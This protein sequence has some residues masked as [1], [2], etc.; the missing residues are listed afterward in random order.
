MCAYVHTYLY[1]FFTNVDFT[2]S[3]SHVYGKYRLV[4]C[5]PM[6]RHVTGA[7]EACETLLINTSY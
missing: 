3:A 4:C 1:L 6:S 7:A 2:D 5:K